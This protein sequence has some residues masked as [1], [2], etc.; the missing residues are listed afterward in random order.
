MDEKITITQD[1]LY[2]IALAY[3]QHGLMC[4]MGIFANKLNE[5]YKLF[6]TEDRR[7]SAFDDFNN[8]TEKTFSAMKEAQKQ[9]EQN[10]GIEL[11]GLPKTLDE[12]YDQIKGFERQ[13]QEEHR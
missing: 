4:G 12:L 10:T 1:D 3:S 13:Y 7:K 6:C 2:N 5:F 9:F 11:F 8:I